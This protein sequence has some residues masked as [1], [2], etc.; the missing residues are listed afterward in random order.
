[1]CAKAHRKRSVSRGGTTVNLAA[2]AR[3]TSKALL[4]SVEGS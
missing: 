2:T 4:E 1:M 3:C